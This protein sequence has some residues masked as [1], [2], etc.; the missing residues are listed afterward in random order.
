MHQ[1][2]GTLLRDDL[3]LVVRVVLLPFSLFDVI[4]DVLIIVRSLLLDDIP[5]ETIRNHGTK[6]REYSLL[7]MIE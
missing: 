4:G 6:K 3:A 1:V 7:I 2:W 5:R